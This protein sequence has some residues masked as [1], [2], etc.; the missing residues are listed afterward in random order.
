MASSSGVAPRR[1]PGRGGSARAAGRATTSAA[2][3]PCPRVCANCT[4]KLENWWPAS[5]ELHDGA[6]RLGRGEEQLLPPGARRARSR[7]E[8]RRPDARLGSQVVALEREVVRARGVAGRNRS[9]KSTSSTPYGS[10][11]SIV[12]PATASPMRTWTAG[13]RRRRALDDVPPRLADQRVEAGRRRVGEGD[14]VEVHGESSGGSGGVGASG[15][16][17][18]APGP[19]ERGEQ[20]A[21]AEHGE[22]ADRVEEVVVA[23]E[24]DDGHRGD[25]V[26]AAS[27]LAQL[28]WTR[29]TSTHAHHSAHGS[30]RS[31]WPRTGWRSC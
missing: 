29:G 7:A 9:R 23:G 10:R 14:V 12:V 5:R 25:R 20:E 24:H 19:G 4:A 27:H 11:S 1:G 15:G 21:D 18:V 8:R 22:A 3:G 17:R 6:V 26:G 16:G 2:S 28:C 13:S 30:G 31:A